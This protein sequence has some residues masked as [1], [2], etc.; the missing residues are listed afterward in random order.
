MNNTKSLSP[1]GRI[2]SAAVDQVYDARRL[3]RDRLDPILARGRVRAGVRSA[4]AEN[5]YVGTLGPLS[6]MRMTISE[7]TKE[8]VRT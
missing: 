5:I 7:G 3:F 4:I 8:A 6:E 1:N 2:W